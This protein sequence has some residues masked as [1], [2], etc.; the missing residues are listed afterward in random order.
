MYQTI[1]CSTLLNVDNP[2]CLRSGALNH[3]QGEESEGLIR[4]D[5][6]SHKYNALDFRS[7]AEKPQVWQ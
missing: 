5:R 4:S 7:P 1:L 3:C 6:L 2:H